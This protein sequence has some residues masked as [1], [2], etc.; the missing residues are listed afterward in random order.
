MDEKRESG[1]AK[2]IVKLLSGLTVH[3]AE[4]VLVLV[5]RLLKEKS[6]VR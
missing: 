5:G 1:I 4:Q 6:V 2:G 3:E